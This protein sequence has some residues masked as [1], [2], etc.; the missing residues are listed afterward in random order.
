MNVT[1]L[2]NIITE[3]IFGEKQITDPVH[4]KG[5]GITQGYK[6][7]EAEIMGATLGSF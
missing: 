4:T 2:C 5:E 6:Y 7:Q 3:V 1:I